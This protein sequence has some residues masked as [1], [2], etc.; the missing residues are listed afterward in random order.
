[1]AEVTMEVVL[2]LITC[3]T[4]GIEFA[5]PKSWNQRRVQDHEWWF[6]PNGHKWQYLQESD[7]T[8]ETRELEL[9]LQAVINEERHRALVA[10]KERDSER[11]K[12]RKIEKRIA[13]GVCPCC[14]R[15]FE[16]LHRHM[17]TKHKHYALA[18][19]EQKQIEGTAQ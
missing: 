18:P 10:E 19:G 13:A 12:R 5:V 2:T 1:M 8:K 11:R 15:T 6:C 4:C 14:N 7:L 3:D 17:A 16:D 9:R